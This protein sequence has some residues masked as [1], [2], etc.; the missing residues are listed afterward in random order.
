M[1]NIL[2]VIPSE[3]FNYYSDCDETSSLLNVDSDEGCYDYKALY[4]AKFCRDPPTRMFRHQESIHDKMQSL[5]ATSAAA[6]LPPNS[7]A[8]NLHMPSCLCLVGSSKYL[9]LCLW[10]VL[11][12]LSVTISLLCICQCC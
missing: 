6:L 7:T 11:T 2:S 10:P 9:S 12:Q 3:A 1:A 4:D 8:V 5:S